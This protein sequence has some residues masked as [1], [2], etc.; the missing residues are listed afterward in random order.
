MARGRAA[1]ILPIA[2][3]AV[4]CLRAAAGLEVQEA[5]VGALNETARHDD[6]VVEG[7]ELPLPGESDN[8]MTDHPHKMPGK[9]S[10]F[11]M[12]FQAED[13]ADYQIEPTGMD[14]ATVSPAETNSTMMRAM[15]ADSYPSNSTRCRGSQ[16]L[17][18]L[19]RDFLN[20]LEQI[21]RVDTYNV[22]ESVQIVK[23]PRANV[24]CDER[25]NDDKET[26]LLDKVHRY[27]RTHV[28]KIQ[29]NKDLSLA[30]K[31]RTFFGCEF[32]KLNPLATGFSRVCAS[33][34]TYCRDARQVDFSITT[35]RRTRR[36]DSLSARRG[37][38]AVA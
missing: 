13:K 20:F 21:S 18:C 19:R 35:S 16:M 33:A 15:T 10:K 34:V 7:N 27:A 6:E 17:S 9:P 26:N 4:A 1:T 5:E 38:E 28:M 12:E 31:A 36:A 30:G 2:I 8:E 22:T 14:N 3:L 11:D 29:L 23:S 37:R 32:P 24:T 25:R